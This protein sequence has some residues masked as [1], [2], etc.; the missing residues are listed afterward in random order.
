MHLS[1]AIWAGHL[2]KLEELDLSRT[3]ITSNGAEVIAAAVLTR[4]PN[5]GKLGLPDRLSTEEQAALKEILKGKIG[6]NLRFAWR[7]E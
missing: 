3:F 7:A 4:C 5:L 6:L 2:T 1:R